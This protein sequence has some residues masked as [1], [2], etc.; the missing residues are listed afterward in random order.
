MSVSQGSVMKHVRCD[1]TFSTRILLLSVPVK[2]FVKV[3]QY[4]QQLWEKVCGILLFTL[5]VYLPLRC[6]YCWLLKV[7]ILQ[8]AGLFFYRMHLLTE[9]LQVCFFCFFCFFVPISQHH[10]IFVLTSSFKLALWLL[11]IIFLE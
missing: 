5:S 3:G 6:M 9:C 4:L 1:G 8:E 7:R 10:S 2:V 11:R